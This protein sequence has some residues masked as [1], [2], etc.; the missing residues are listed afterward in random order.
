MDQPGREGTGQRTK[1]ARKTARDSAALADMEARNRDK[2]GQG[3][4]QDGQYMR[5]ALSYVKTDISERSKRI[6][7]G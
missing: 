1:Q 3:E 7:T 5:S 4:S 2:A 6:G